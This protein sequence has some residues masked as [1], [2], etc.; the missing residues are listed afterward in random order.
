MFPI[1]FFDFHG[2]VTKNEK[3]NEISLANFYESVQI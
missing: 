3:K 2:N 1:I